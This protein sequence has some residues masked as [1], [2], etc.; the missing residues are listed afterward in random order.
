[1]TT[2]TDVINACNANLPNNAIFNAVEKLAAI[3]MAIRG[4]WPH[5][6]E[7]GVDSSLTIA[8]TTYEYTPTE[9]PQLEK[10]Y[11]I[12]YVTIPSNP[13]MKLTRVTQRRDGTAWT[14]ILPVDIVS[15]LI[16]QVLHLQY[17]TTYA[18]IT[19]LTDTINMPLDYLEKYTTY[20]LCLIG[21]ARASEF[22]REV[23][24]RLATVYQPMAEQAKRANVTEGVEFLIRSVTEHG[25]NLSSEPSSGIGVYL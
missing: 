20:R 22:D 8:S 1:M 23:Y 3:N 7:V 10:G 25:G 9:Q 18:A 14:I 24:E 11:A 15:G 12:A 2:G 17:F 13:K 21:M 6:V 16:G 19:G 5:I 4:G